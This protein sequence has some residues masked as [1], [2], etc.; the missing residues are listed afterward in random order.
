MSNPV[1][2][3]G[4]NSIMQAPK[5]AGPEECS[6]LQVFRTTD[7]IISCWRL[8][9]VEIANVVETGVVWL[10]IKGQGMPPV[11]I[12]GDALVEIEGR[13]SKAEPYIPIAKR[14]T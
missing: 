11:M 10:S 13:P 3:E 7:Q 5:G 9:D 6:D 2:F 14:K 12:S 1:G 4:A 8:T